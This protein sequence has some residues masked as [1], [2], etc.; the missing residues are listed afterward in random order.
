MCRRTIIVIYAVR[1]SYII[2]VTS[3]LCVRIPAEALAYFFTLPS[4]EQIVD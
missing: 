4:R 1:A 2:Y 3:K